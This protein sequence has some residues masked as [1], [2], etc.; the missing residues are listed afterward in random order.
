LVGPRGRTGQCCNN[1]LAD[2]CFGSIK[3]EPLDLQPWPIR[4]ARR[5]VVVE[6]KP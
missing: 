3:G 1:A 5:R 4:A 6:Y 2:S